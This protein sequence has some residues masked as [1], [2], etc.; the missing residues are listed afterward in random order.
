GWFPYGPLRWLAGTV[1]VLVAAA[2]V[3]LE[4]GIRIDRPTG[5][6]W[7]VLLA[8]LAIGAVLGVEGIYAWTGTP[9]RSL[10][11]A[12]WVLFAAA[13]VVG[14]QVGDGDPRGEARLR[15]GLLVAA[16]GIGMVAAAEAIG[17]APDPI[18]AGSGR[19][20]ATLGNAAF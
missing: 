5:R 11:V 13:F 6:A 14:Q 10:G 9:E 7:L 16:A 15:A 12:T 4:G 8:L 3:V 18:G 17:V 19:L 2:L 20:G 1:L